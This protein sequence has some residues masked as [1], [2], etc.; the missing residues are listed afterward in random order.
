MATNYKKN[1]A[2]ILLLAV[3]MIFTLFGCG[4]VGENGEEIQNA[5]QD[6]DVY[7]GVVRR[8][9][10]PSLETVDI[11]E[12]A[13]GMSGYKRGLTLLDYFHY[14]YGDFTDYQIIHKNPIKASNAV[15]SVEAEAAKIQSSG[16]G[17]Y[18][19]AEIMAMTKGFRLKET[20]VEYENSEDLNKAIEKV[21]AVYNTTEGL[22]EAKNALS[23]L[24][25]EVKSALT[26]YLSAS[27]AALKQNLMQNENIT[28]SEYKNVSSFTYCAPATSNFSSMQRAYETHLKIDEN[29]MVKTGLLMIKASSE[30]IE[31]LRNV[32]TYTSDDTVLTVDTPAGKIILGSSGDD[33]YSDA[34]AFLIADPDGNDA[35]GGKAASNA[36]KTQPISVL[37]DFNGNDKYSAKNS[38]GASQGSGIF[39]VGLL[40]D[41]NGDDEYKAVRIS[42]GFSFFGTGMLFDG[43]GNDEYVSELNSQAAGYYG[44]SMHIDTFGDDSFKS[45]GYSQASAG[46]RN[47]SFL[48]NLRG[49]DT[50]YVT[51]YPDYKHGELAYSQF[52]AINGNWSQ[53]C[54][55]GQR[56]V[57]VP[58][59]RA[60]AGGFAAIVDIGG[61]DVYTGGIWTQGVGYWAGVGILC[62]VG[63]NDKY[64]SHYYSQASVAHSG[65]GILTDIG[66]D[67]IHKV[68]HDTYGRD[69]AGDGASIGFV[70]DRGVALFVNDGGDDE[71]YAKQTSGGRAWSAYDEKGPLKQDHTYAFF[72]ETEGND[73]YSPG[74]TYVFNSYGRGGYFID[75]GGEDTYTRDPLANGNT[76]RDEACTKGGVFYD[77]IQSENDPVNAVVGFW[78]NALSLAFGGGE[79]DGNE[80]S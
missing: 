74:D 11:G 6:P 29:E 55:V 16:K 52:P 42:Q 65:A 40:Y 56:N 76:L 2:L 36:S 63:G 18:E 59:E 60:L 33:T 14:G 71:Y 34:E 58:G 68:S 78:E 20:D 62:D 54:G 23:R 9:V 17:V 69:V 44:L 75:C 13:I 67:D 61:D 43:K 22:K 21:F 31:A 15:M 8:T 49:N 24:N 12:L 57:T 28:D 73:Y 32:K 72:I 77:F 50:Y 38:D 4:V 35:Y 19:F 5:E 1:K 37:I 47:M 25:K 66:G 45:Y 7:E 53:G 46:N 48:V 3:S 10:D 51:P 64:Y 27:A 80:L 41:M 26:A 39:G 79:S 30:L 70:W